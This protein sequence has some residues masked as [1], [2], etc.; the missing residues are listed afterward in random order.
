ME[1]PMCNEYCS[2]P[3]DTNPSQKFTVILNDGSILCNQC[4]DIKEWVDICGL[5]NINNPKPKTQIQNKINETKIDIIK[6]FKLNESKKV[7]ENVEANIRLGFGMDD[8]DYGI[9]AQI[10][11]DLGISKMRLISNNPKK[12]T[13]LIGYGLEIVEN[14]PTETIPNAHNKTYLKTKKDKMGHTLNLED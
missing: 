6:E 2:L 11:R 13:G 3:T 5:N 1:C 8:R 9:G 4:Q 12:R 14:V 7:L 10:I